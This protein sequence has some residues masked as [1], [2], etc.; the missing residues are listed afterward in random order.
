MTSTI[1][2]TEDAT[3]SAANPAVAVKLANPQ[4]AVRR[5]RTVKYEWE[6]ANDGKGN[7]RL[8]VLSIS[9]HIRRTSSA[10]ARSHPSLL[11]AMLRNENEES[12]EEGRPLR[13]TTPFSG[14]SICAAQVRR[15]SQTQMVTFAEAAL[16]RLRS[17]CEQQD[18]H[19]A[20]YFREAA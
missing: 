8:A 6:L 4:R 3:P 11:A 1:R 9:H 15:F 20:R 5:D 19:V 2:T 17:L 7:R 14:Y 13:S 12:V 10:T 18:E 16:L